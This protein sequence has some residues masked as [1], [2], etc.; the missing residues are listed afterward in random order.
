MPVA[1][2]AAHRLIAVLTSAPLAGAKRYAAGI[3]VVDRLAG[4]SVFEAG[5]PSQC[6]T[7]PTGI[8]REASHLALEPSSLAKSEMPFASRPQAREPGAETRPPPIRKTESAESAKPVIPTA[9]AAQPDFAV[10]RSRRFQASSQQ[11]F[12]LPSIQD[13]WS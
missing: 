9:L 8:K 10:A 11:S 7:V 13:A 5:S 1:G 6:K 4:F 2:G 12:A 3:D